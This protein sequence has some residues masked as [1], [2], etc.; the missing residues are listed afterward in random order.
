MKENETKL[1]LKDLFPNAEMGLGNI[2]FLFGA[3]TSYTAG[4]PL[5][6][7]LTKNVLAKLDQNKTLLLKQILNK[8]S[9]E[10]ASEN[11]S[12]DIEIISDILNK[13]KNIGGIKGIDSLISDIKTGIIEILTSIEKVNYDYHIQFFHALK[14]KLANSKSD[15]WIFTTNYDLVFETAASMA[16][17]PVFNGFE[18]IN[19]RY[20][21]IRNLK[22]QRG[23]VSNSKFEA[24]P[25]PTIKIVKLHGSIS[26]EKSEGL[27]QEKFTGIEKDNSCLIL[28]QRTKVIDT[29]DSPYDSL[30]RLANEI[31]GN[32]CEYLVS[33]GFSYRD[34]HIND[35][36]IIPKLRSG[37]I[38]LFA[39]SKE[40]N[41]EIRT[42]SEF[43]A[44]KYGTEDSLKIGSIELQEGTELWDFKKLV[45]LI[46]K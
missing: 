44:F 17:V 15:I 33:C 46:S 28:P 16:G 40:T 10:L 39:L 4:Y 2:G 43:N 3:G 21:D 24:I 6:W 25:E 37:K 32:E 29:L 14:K 36:L 26:W 19:L 31:L 38:N 45:D 13:H 41:A 34:Q 20:F 5:T 8:E 30:F 1:T 23:T 42:L 12:P 22:L 9:L 7:E 11:G 35:H 27:V 18:G